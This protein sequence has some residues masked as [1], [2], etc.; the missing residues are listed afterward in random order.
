MFCDFTWS[1]GVVRHHT[2][3]R[4]VDGGE[5]TQNASLPVE[6]LMGGELANWMKPSHLSSSPEALKR[7]PILKRRLPNSDNVGGVLVFHSFSTGE[8]D[9]R[10]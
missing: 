6:K 9:E 3:S 1:P 4:G 8:K 7:H 5:Q 10:R 2:P